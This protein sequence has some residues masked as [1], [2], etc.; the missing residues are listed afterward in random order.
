[1][2]L[3]KPK[4]IVLEAVHH[5]DDRGNEYTTIE[6]VPEYIWVEGYKGTDA[7]MMCR[8]QQYKLNTKYVIAGDPVK[9]ANGYH[10][11][12]EINYVFD[13]Y[14]WN[15]SNR[16]FKVKALVKKDEWEHK[17]DK[18]VAAAIIFTEELFYTYEELVSFGALTVWYGN[19]RWKRA[20]MP[21]SLF[22]MQKESLYDV[23]FQWYINEMKNL[24]HS[25]TFASLL[26]DRIENWYWYV[27]I[28][29]I[30]RGLVDE[31]VS[32]DMRVYLLSQQVERMKV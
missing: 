1:M 28:I 22:E 27:N 24:G 3:F 17:D 12:K 14:K 4:P 15:F 19:T 29:E 2:G 20:I 13:H 18:Y 6:E 10:F 23:T 31:G 32:N 21:K 16:Y 7:D 9:C 5:Y 30:S 25:E 11:C 26:V 8:G